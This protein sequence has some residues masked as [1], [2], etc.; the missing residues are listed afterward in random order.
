MRV[1]LATL[2]HEIAKESAALRTEIAT[3][4]VDIL[5]WAIGSWIASLAL[6]AA[7]FH[8]GR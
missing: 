3:S 4:K 6:I 7:L 2:Q 8:F 5:K 1:G